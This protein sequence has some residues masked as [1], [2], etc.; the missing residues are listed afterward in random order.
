[1][2][3]SGGE[4]EGSRPRMWSSSPTFV[5]KSWTDCPLRVRVIARRRSKMVLLGRGSSFPPPPARRETHTTAFCKES[6]A[7]LKPL[8]V[9]LYQKEG[10]SPCDKEEK[11]P[12]ARGAAR[13]VCARVYDCGKGPSIC[14]ICM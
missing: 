1:M 11:R 2:T 14:V 6:R 13:S 12:S 4:R 5:G 8:L 9:L 3:L 7:G 10:Y